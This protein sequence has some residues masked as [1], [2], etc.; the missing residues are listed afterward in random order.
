MLHHPWVDERAAPLYLWRVPP[1]PSTEALTESLAAIRHWMPT[2]DGPYGWINDPRHLRIAVIASQRKMLAEHLREVQL[3]ASRW[4]AGMATI[5]SHPAIRGIG[6]AV[7]WVTP[8]PFPIEW[9]ADLDEAWT[10][11]R[12][13]LLERGAEG[14]PSVPPRDVRE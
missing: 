4:C 14:V 10:W 7:G 6:T 8:Y 2:L 1:E 11:T 13:R 5:V 9:C 12:K 3:H